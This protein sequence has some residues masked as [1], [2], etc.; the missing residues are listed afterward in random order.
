MVQSKKEYLGSLFGDFEKKETPEEI[1]KAAKKIKTFI[2]KNKNLAEKALKDFPTVIGRIKYQKKFTE[3]EY[4]FLYQ[5]LLPVVYAIAH[6]HL[7]F[8]E[9]RTLERVSLELNLFDS[10]ERLFMNTHRVYQAAST[11]KY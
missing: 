11:L 2:Q 9:E 3:E 1:I 7:H 8:C 5:N 6:Q 10:M 4:K